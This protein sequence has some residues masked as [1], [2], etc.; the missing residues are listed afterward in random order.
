MT[1]GRRRRRGSLAYRA[2]AQNGKSAG[3]ISAASLG[4]V[5]S[6]P[7]VAALDVVEDE[8]LEVPREARAA[9]GDGLAAVDKDRGRGL[10]AGAGQ[11]DSDIGVLR[12]S[13]PVH[14]AAHD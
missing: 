4:G 7:A 10:L 14:D 13:R 6:R 1:A 2:K 8:R 11:G 5:A 12:L 9:Q 3:R